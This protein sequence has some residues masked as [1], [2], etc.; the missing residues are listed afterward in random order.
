VTAE[1]KPKI[2]QDNVNEVRHKTSRTSRNNE[3][4]IGKAKLRRL[5]WTVRTET[6][7]LH[8]SVNEFKKCYLHRTNLV[9]D[10]KSDQLTDFHNILSGWKIYFCQL[11]K[12]H[13]VNDVMQTEMHVSISNVQDPQFCTERT[14]SI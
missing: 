13:G 4:H 12:A 1:S 6:S 5:K 10:E 9:T 11:L 14:N 8:R 2:I 7:D 3:E